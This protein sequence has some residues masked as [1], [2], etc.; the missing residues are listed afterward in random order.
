MGKATDFEIQ[1][2][3]F[4]QLNTPD[5]DCTTRECSSTCRRAIR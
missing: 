1:M 5:R 3:V 4:Y 2:Q